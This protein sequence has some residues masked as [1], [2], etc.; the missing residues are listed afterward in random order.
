MPRAGT[1][2]RHV[3]LH[4]RPQTTNDS[5]GYWEALSPPDAWVSIE[6]VDSGIQDDTRMIL[7]RVTMPFHT[8]VTVDTRLTYD[9]R[10]LNRTRYFYVKSVQN[11]SE[12]NHT[13]VCFCE[14]VIP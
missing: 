7:S 12:G 13:L 5:D 11:L 6:P 4:R 1:R 10:L 2:N 3:T 9:D 14:E 8:Q